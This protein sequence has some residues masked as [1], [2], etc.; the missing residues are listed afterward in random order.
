MYSFFLLIIFTQIIIYLALQMS[1]PI[2]QY[3]SCSSFIFRK[4]FKKI[5]EENVAILK[6][7]ALIG[8]MQIFEN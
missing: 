8:I 6:N 3:F 7:Y 1:D 2:S 5:E 4:K